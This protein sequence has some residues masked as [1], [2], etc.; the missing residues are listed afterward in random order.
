[1]C[2]VSFL[3]TG[4]WKISPTSGENDVTEALLLSIPTAIVAPR[5]GPHICDQHPLPFLVVRRSSYVT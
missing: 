1:M 5:K 4:N 2:A 3:K